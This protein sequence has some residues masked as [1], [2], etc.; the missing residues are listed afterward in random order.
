MSDSKSFSY[1]K[2]VK[3][4]PF[5]AFVRTKTAKGKYS[6]EFPTEQDKDALDFS[7]F[8][9][10]LTDAAGC[11]DIVRTEDRENLAR[12]IEKSA[13][14]MT[15]SEESFGVILPSGETRWLIGG[16]LPQKKKNGD[17]VWSG[18]WLDATAE[19]KRDFFDALVVSNS[20]EGIVAFDQQGQ[21]LS[22]S[23]SLANI[24][25]CP[26]EDISSKSMFSLLPADAVDAVQQYML[27]PT[28]E[29][30]TIEFPSLKEDGT[31]AFFEIDLIQ[32][33][34]I[35]VCLFRDVTEYHKREEKLRYLAYHD[36][37]TGVENY[38][39]LK[40]AFDKALEQSRVSQTQI[41]VLSIAL[42]SLGQLNA[43]S[44]QSI[45]ARVIAAMAERFRACLQP[46]DVLA[47]VSSYRFTILITELEFA[48]GLEKKIEAILHSLNR[49]IIID[50]MEF[51]LSISIGVCFCPQDGEKLEDLIYR[52]DLALEKGAN[53]P[54]TLHVYN[55][56]LSIQATINLNMRRNLKKA[57]EN[58]E[59]KAFFQP[60]V[61]IKTGRIV[62]MEALARWVS[63]DG[64]VIP[65][66]EFLSEAEEYGL[67]D[68]LTEVILKLA[69][70]W[71]Q[72]WYSAGLCCVPV[73]VNI[74]G[75]QFHNETHLL[76]MVDKALEE[77]D[78][79]P[80]LLELELT[81][82]SAMYDPENA[83]RI[84]RA[85]LDN[86]IRCALDDFGTGYSSLGVLR[87]FP[88]KKLKIDRSFILELDEH[89]NLE[90]VRAT[91]AMA[92]ALNLTVLAEGVEAR[93]HF[94]ALK[95][96]G[97]DIIQGYL[98][99]RPLPP[100]QMELMLSRWN[101]DAA[102]RGEMF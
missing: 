84:I 19:K 82:S 5:I 68:A 96:L 80:Y 57:L 30:T 61:D 85:L 92:H 1:A 72:K 48:L 26:V 81:E 59:I 73:A 100:K 18:L 40:D 42:D 9:E 45:H 14:E 54:G 25:S 53:K 23:P 74:S 86:N 63:S 76:S 34:N 64:G 88:L 35:F 62:G 66:S 90:I 71:N 16:A 17:I 21:I 94:N 41:A 22:F 28:Q 79:P 3:N 49:P 46:N 78:L 6:Y 102:L 37:D 97:C 12:A 39:F 75:R 36:I 70:Q 52:A 10:I 31:E 83:K 60:Q 44:D 13:R 67:I 8:D 33:N 93:R 56:D 11:L 32:K 101:S 27:M 20:R 7:Q 77:S 95:D 50:D 99:S 29:K 87:S 89:E 55:S 4:L 15:V 69:C 51:D 98:F 2:V 38:S 43:L 65:P 91:I 24:L 58:D 47:Q